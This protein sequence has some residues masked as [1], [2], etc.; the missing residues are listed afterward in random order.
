[1]QMNLSAS[2]LNKQDLDYEANISVKTCIQPQH[3]KMI[4]S[5]IL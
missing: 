3:F 5:L 4:D 2:F 1:M